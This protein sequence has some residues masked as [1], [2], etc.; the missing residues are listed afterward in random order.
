MSE[1]SPRRVIQ[2]HESVIGPPAPRPRSIRPR[3]VADYPDVPA[4]YLEVA[5]KLSSPL[6]MGPP[7]CDELIAFV[8]H[9]FTEEEASLVRHLRKYHKKTADEIARLEHRPPDAVAPILRRLAVEKRAIA[10]DDSKGARR[11]MLMP[12]FPGIFEMVLIGVAPDAL[13]DWH[14][15]FSEL[16]EAL[17]ET[18]YSTEYFDRRAPYVKFL[19]VHQSIEAHPMAL[20]S[21]RLEVIFD[22]FEAFG[23][24]HCQ[25][26]MAEQANGR[27]CGRPTGNCIAA[28]RFAEAGIRDGWLRSISKASALAL[29]AEAESHGL[30]TWI[31][32]VQSDK[33]QLTCSCC[34]C[35]CHAMRLV[36]EFNAPGL[37]APP[38]FTPR[39]DAA[40]CN[41]CGR[42]ARQCPMA[43]LTVDLKAKTLARKAERCIGCGLCALACDN[44]HAI[45]MEPVPA[46][47]LPYRSW[48]AL[49]MHNL[50]GQARS[51]W[52]VWRNR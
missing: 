36:S 20:P 33:G 51:I 49:M 8:H 4:A 1:R 5:Q 34:G 30:V 31:M 52:K 15:R 44:A 39:L 6:L 43:A 9:V 10:C 38:H 11:Y 3:K 29:K 35:C 25:C 22:R 23:V 47:E 41:H 19:P 37:M 42:C 24:G 40:R 32:N 27:G 26:R 2:I 46:N 50:P 48:F 18:G 14:R 21:Q 7:I 16:F 12:I 28:G 13:T 17:Y 45:S